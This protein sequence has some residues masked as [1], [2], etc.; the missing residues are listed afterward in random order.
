VICDGINRIDITL[1]A[2]QPATI[3]YID[4]VLP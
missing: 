3:E 1:E 4:V 2:G